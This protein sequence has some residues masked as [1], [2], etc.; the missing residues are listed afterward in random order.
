MYIFNAFRA[1]IVLTLIFLIS[2]SSEAV[3]ISNN[4]YVGALW[5]AESGGI[6]K[7]ATADG[8]V[9]FEIGDVKD[10]EALALDDTHGVLWSYGRGLLTRFAFNG[11]ITGSYDVG[12]KVHRKEHLDFQRRDRKEERH[13]CQE[14]NDTPIAISV[15]PSDGSLWLARG[16]KLSHY[17]SN[18]VILAE[19]VSDKAI[20][21]IAIS[22]LTSNIWLIDKKRLYRVIDN[23]VSLTLQELLKERK[24]LKAIAYDEY[25]QELWLATEKELIRINESGTEQFRQYSKHTRHLSPDYKS[26]LWVTT[27]HSVFKLDATGLLLLETDLLRGSHYGGDITTMVADKS[28]GSLWLANKKQL[29]HLDSV[30]QVL[31]EI[32]ERKH[33]RDIR[34]LAIY[35][36]TTA[37]N[38]NITLPLDGSYLNTN[39]PSINVSYSDNGMGVDGDSLKL[40]INGAEAAVTCE[41]TEQDAQCH[42]AVPL[43]EGGTVLA[44]QVSDYAGNT[45]D[46]ATITF[47]VDTVPPVITITAPDNGF[48]TNQTPLAISGSINETVTATLNGNSLTLDA[49]NQFSISA[50]LTEGSNSFEITATDLAGNSATYT[51][52]GEL[53]TVAPQS[54]NGDLITV[55]IEAGNAIVTG[56]SG[57]AEPGSWITIT[58]ASTGE[59]ITVQVAADGSFSAQLAVTSGD[60]LVIS[61]RDGAGNVAAEDVT[62]STGPVEPPQPNN[63]YVPVDP[64][65][66]APPIDP[67]VVTS[68][69]NSTA[70]LY[71]GSH[72]IQFDVPPN[73]IEERR[74]VV[75]RGKVTTRGGEALKGVTITILNHNEFGWTG[76]RTDGMFDMA[77]N[78]GG[79]LTVNYKK[80]GYLPV[81]RQINAPW[82]DYAWLPEVVMIPLDNNVT[83]VDLNSTAPFQ[84][85]QGSVM[86][87]ADGSRQAT[88][89][90]PQGVQ[91]EMVMADG[92]TQPL[93][94]M[95]VRATE[96]T[97]GTEGANTMPGELPPSSGYTYAVELSV[98]EAIAAGANTVQFSQPLPVYVDNFI[99]FPVGG[100]VPVGWYDRD[101]AAWIPSE[102][103]RVIE[104]L[105]VTNGMADIDVD[106]SG[107]ADNAAALSA[108]GI[109]EAERLQL[110]QLYQPGKSLWRAPI[111]H[112]TPW[113][114]NWPYGPPD[115]AVAPEEDIHEAD[116]KID[117][118]DCQTGSIIECQNQVL[119]ESIPID[120]TPFALTYRSDR[121]PGRKA[122]YTLHIP[123]SGATLPNSLQRIDLEIR[124]AGKRFYQSFSPQLNMTYT[125]EWDEKDTFGRNVRGVEKAVVRIGYVYNAVYYDPTIFGR[126]FAVPGRKDISK[127]MQRMEVTL[128]QVS[129][130]SLGTSQALATGLGGWSLT[131]LHRYSQNDAT[132]YLGNGLR[133]SA[134]NIS[135]NIETVAG[136]GAGCNNARDGGLATEEPMCTPSSIA[137]GSDGSIY[138]SEPQEYKIR[139]I[140]PDGVISTVAGD[141]A[142]GFSGDGG[143]AVNAKI[144]GPRGLSFGPDGSLYFAD[145]GNHR[146]RRISP[147]GII[148]TIAGSG[149]H[150]ENWYVPAAF[151]GDNGPATEARLSTPFDVEVANDGTIYIAD[152]YNN[153]IR[154]VGLDGVI[155]TIAGIGE[156]NFS[157]DGGPATEARLGPFGLDLGSDGS[158][159][160][161]DYWNQRVRRIGPD[162]IIDTVAGGGSLYADDINNK[163]ATDAHLQ[164]PYDVA[165]GSDGSLYI[166]DNSPGRVY[167]VDTSGI[168]A[169]VAGT[170]GYVYSGDGGPAAIAGLGAAECVEMGSDGSFYICGWRR[171]RRVSGHANLT[172]SGDYWATSESGREYYLFSQS[173]RHLQTVDTLTGTQIYTFTYDSNGYVVT[174][175]DEWGAITTIERTAEGAPLA[176]IAPEGQ[177]TVVTLNENGYLSKASNS[178]GE[179]YSMAYTSD[180]LLISFT[181]PRGNSSAM[182]Y[183]ELGRLIKDQGAAGNLWNL[184]RTDNLDTYTVNMT[185]AEGRLTSHLVENLPGGDIR[186]VNTLQNGIR[187]E[188]LVYADGHS[189]I[190]ESDGTVVS[191]E[192]KPDPRFG[193]DAP[194]LAASSVVT[195]AGITQTMSAG[196][197]I[198]LSDS[199]NLLSLT[200]LSETT[201][202]NGLTSTTAYDA[203]THT[204]TVT[205]PSGRQSH[206]EVNDKGRPVIDQR[207]DLN[208][209]TYSYDNRG[210]MTSITTG[211]GI[212]ARNLAFDYDTQ[213]YLSSITDPLGRRVTFTNDAVGRVTEQKLPDGRKIQY[214]YDKNGNLTSLTP[215]GKSAHV[216]SYNAV[217]KETDYTPP[218]L[219]G[220]QTITHYVYNLDKQLTEVLRPD[221][222]TVT[223][224]YNSGGK[225]ATLTIPRGQYV[226][227]YNATTGK[228]S[229][230]TAP[231]GSTLSYSYDGFLPLSTTWAGDI[232]GSVSQAYDNNF[233]ISSRSVKGSAISY[234]YDDDGLLTQAGDLTLNRSPVNGLLTGTTL[235]NITTSRTYNGFGEMSGETAQISGTSA[236]DTQYER[237]KLGRITK[238]TE[239]IEGV[240]SVYDYGYDLA[241]RLQTVSKDGAVVSTYTYD[242]NGNRIDHNGTG[243]TYDEQ[244]RLLTYGGAS[245]SYTLNGELES[246][247]ES[248]LI[249]QY[250]YDLL[251]NLMQATLPGGMTLNYLIDGQNRRVGKKVDG[252]LTQGFLYQ[253]QLNPIAEL[254]GA[255]NVVARFVYA[256]KGNVPSY[257]VK[258][259]VA[260]R[261]ISDHLG[262]P[263][264]IVNSSTGEIVQRMDYDE[265]GNVI[266][267][268]NPGFQPFGFAGGIYD[269][270]TQLTRFG[271][272]DYDA[273]TGRWTAKDPISFKGGDTN[274][275]AYVISDP[276]NWVDPKGHNAAT[277]TAGAAIGSFG[278]PVGAVIGGIIGFGAGAWGSYEFWN[279]YNNDNANEDGAD[280]APAYPDNPDSSPG[281]FSPIKGSRGKQCE[282]G[283]VWEKDRSSHGGEQW[284]RWPNKKSWER[285]DKPNS[286]WPDGRIRK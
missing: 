198:V 143:L 263:R 186:R 117:D 168:I 285:G 235:S 255:G 279:W 109:T 266:N 135:G 144:C 256:E 101:K 119:G 208:A 204:W 97:V 70:F 161:A 63:G 151:A 35:H 130:K 103:G 38:L 164:E 238:K 180:G 96:Y 197:S 89:L 41:T 174:I 127:D 265:F 47:T 230:T 271:A 69:Y 237:D 268:T 71:S 95:N 4:D 173:R 31:H 222:Q 50:D 209:A 145:S 169:S 132:L 1:L 218:A 160:V 240:T 220:A 226:Y 251:G 177:R 205:G 108:L 110:A 100:I 196:R 90:F 159:Y 57:S 73:T 27:E 116:E 170:S 211:T 244:D 124:V 272:R 260:Y 192:K 81:Q 56:A 254:D 7:L 19:L 194:Y 88:L 68:L 42:L 49:Q 6:L 249:T 66:V 229:T 257:M 212:T 189:V 65:S 142:S 16:R 46:K 207:F 36:D 99:G 166:A 282:D 93:T 154:R 214:S 45:S 133:K 79:I 39:L 113:D 259:G 187:N 167:K 253:D 75:L 28:D 114:C 138:F 275:Y 91:A 258:G 248:G 43:A 139:R 270:H 149:S 274:L 217:D 183:D 225:L 53:D 123:L 5:V 216:F 162:G 234:G 40:F 84:V 125:F 9:L 37:P 10:I 21:A 92:S 150:C 178:L 25:L 286:I 165:I 78:G 267:D 121:V 221:G 188:K 61:V 12:C 273:K 3:T 86:T 250:H 181:D 184:A 153:R 155:T 245:Y 163:P 202:V 224:G 34:A 171:I 30:G 284:K 157:G 11:S 148:T 104:I 210:R 227:D 115:D 269:L 111:T 129:S 24:E 54:V 14:N 72:P 277:A 94:S 158:L 236:L 83:T 206:V 247:T 280:D 232:S 233:W 64:A 215:P 152:T 261:I 80:E 131:P 243:A 44:A 120:G 74:V 15:A 182:T 231:D 33:H 278:G 51:F 77:V 239:S 48:V 137:I 147:D 199:S 213:G 59:S 141:G 20:T 102:N 172:T 190:T 179:A 203:A 122:A 13:Q 262:S 136:T 201:T 241:G 242:L 76:T 246:K 176:I 191:L 223:L 107:T 140:G 105:S 32:G 22:P 195:P 82:K 185:S 118:P 17:D 126:A 62:V 26:A 283:S 106:G 128:W 85:A 8:T 29:I 112:F 200:S 58:N 23:G 276:I 18:G 228:L 146:I 264:L 156:Y 60:D 67:T 252:V 175:E 52:T 2:L 55:I 193:M 98:D 134:G 87:D 281:D 219:S